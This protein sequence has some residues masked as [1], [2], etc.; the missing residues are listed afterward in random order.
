MHEYLDATTSTFVAFSA[1]GPVVVSTGVG[2]GTGLVCPGG[3]LRHG[4]LPTRQPVRQLRSA[5][6]QPHVAAHGQLRPAV[7]SVRTKGAPVSVHELREESL[8]EARSGR[9]LQKRGRIGNPSYVGLSKS[10]GWPPAAQTE[11]SWSLFSWTFK[12]A[13]AMS[14]MSSWVP[15]NGPEAHSMAISWQTRSQMGHAHCS[16]YCCSR[17]LENIFW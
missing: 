7:V 12:M 10:C 1:G 6:E 16:R 3:G 2:P 13:S 8:T 5:I 11:A 14:S 15:R 4:L 17:C 9:G